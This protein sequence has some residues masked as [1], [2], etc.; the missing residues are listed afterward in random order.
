MYT[1]TYR[2]EDGTEVQSYGV[3]AGSMAE[4]AWTVAKT[5]APDVEF[6]DVVRVR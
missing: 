2:L 3:E 5:V 6:V 1:V 4:A